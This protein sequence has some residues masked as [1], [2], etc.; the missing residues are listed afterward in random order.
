MKLIIADS[1]SLILMAKCNLLD[2]LTEKTTLLIPDAVFKE[3]VNENTIEKYSD[4]KMVSNLVEQERI[5]VIAVKR[6]KNLPFVMGRGELEAL[7]LMKQMPDAVLAT[8]DGKA[9]KACR[10]LKLPF[11]ISP[12]I[13]VELYRMKVLDKH[14]AKAA[15]EKMK[16]IGRY[17][18]D[19]IAEAL[20]M[21]EEVKDA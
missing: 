5:K 18:A 12:K 11:I 10:H 7:L 1:C 13:A 3:V 15:I 14:K 17:S 20:L 16:L 19:I 4:A 2:I 8:D 6:P 21:L 9:I